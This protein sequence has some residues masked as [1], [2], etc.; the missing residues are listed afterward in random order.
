[1]LSVREREAGFVLWELMLVVIAVLLFS[2][3]AVPRG[4]RL[5]RQMAVEYE[6]EHLLA[7][8]RHCQSLSR[9][10]AGDARQ[11]GAKKAYQKFTR[12]DIY[13]EYK[14]I[15]AGES[16]ILDVNRFF[17]GVHIERVNK[18][19]ELPLGDTTIQIAFLA[20]GMTRLEK[21]MGLVTVLV[22]FQGYPQEGR[23]IMVSSG[24]RIRM[25]RG[26]K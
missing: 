12:M 5:Y 25:E 8:I 16:I 14:T 10:L 22:Y 6:A 2:T 15:S 13:P 24:G 9:L 7:D 21:D 23:W 1:M 19:G 11:Y 26:S 18:L 17:P 3:Q 20:N 4:F